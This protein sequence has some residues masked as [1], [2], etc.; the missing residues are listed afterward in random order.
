MAIG[1]AHII[2]YCAK[3]LL[4]KKIIG[5]IITYHLAKI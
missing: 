2:N 5:Q 4:K 3:I 1:Q